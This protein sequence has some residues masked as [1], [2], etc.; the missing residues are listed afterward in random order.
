MG[1]HRKER[2]WYIQALIMFISKCDEYEYFF[3]FFLF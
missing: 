1:I 2:L 3:A